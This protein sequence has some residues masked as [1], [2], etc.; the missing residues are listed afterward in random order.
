MRHF[1]TLP[2]VA[3]WLQRTHCTFA[4]IPWK[5]EWLS[6]LG[7]TFRHPAIVGATWRGFIFNEDVELNTFIHVDRTPEGGWLVSESTENLWED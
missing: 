1:G 4:G 5:D 3:H 2:E 6:I 7:S